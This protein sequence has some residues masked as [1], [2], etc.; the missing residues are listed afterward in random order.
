MQRSTPRRLLAIALV[1]VAIV[2]V[3]CISIFGFY[4]HKY[5]VIVDRR[6]E[7]PLFVNTAQIYAAARQ[8]RT[9]QKLTAATVAAQ[10]RAAGYTDDSAP[11]KSQMGTFAVTDESITIRPGTQSFHAPE[12]ATI[13]FDSSGASGVSRVQQI[14]ATNGEQLAS[15]ALEPLLITGLSD[16]NRAKRRLITYGELPKYL[17]PAVTSIEDRRFFSHGGVDYIRLLGAAR[18]DLLHHGYHGSTEGGSTLTMQLA[19]GFFLTPAKHIK[20]KLLEILIT[21]HLEHRFSKEQIFQLYANEIPLGQAGSFAI[22]GFGEAAQ[23]YFG[24]DVSRLDLPECA[25]LAG[26]IQS[27]SRLTP[28]RHPVRAVERRNLVL[29]AMVETGDI[30]KE[31]AEEAK[32]EPLRLAPLSDQQNKAPYFVDLVRDQI[33][34]KLGDATWNQ[35]GLRIYTSLDPQLQAAA[36]A[37]V[38]EGMKHVDEL[39]D[40]RHAKAA[41]AGEPVVYPQVALVALDPHTGQV[42][43][44]VGGRNYGQ[45]QLNHAASHRPTGSIFK[46]FVYASAFNSSLAG[47]QLTTPD[48]KTGVFN[49]AMMLPDQQQTFEFG[50]GQTYTPRNFEGEYQDEVTAQFALKRSLNNATIL[51]AQMVGFGNVAALARDAGI[52]SARATPSVAIGTYAAS[53]LEMAGAYTIF[54]NG[55]TAIKPQLLASIR[56]SSGDP[57]QDFSAQTHP[58]LDPRVAYLTTNMM[59]AVLQ[60]NGTGAGVRSMGFNAPAAGKTGTENDAW[61]VGYTS[62]LLCIVWVGNDDYSDLKL[63][64]ADAAGPIWGNFMKHAVALPQYSDTHE[65]AVPAGVTL[66]NLDKATNLLADATCPDD[67][68]AAF[69]DGTQPLNTCDGPGNDQRNI[70]QKLFGIGHDQPN[71]TQQQ[72]QQQVPAGAQPALPGGQPQQPAPTTLNGAQPPATVPQQQQQPAQDKKPGFFGRLFGH[73]P[74]QEQAPQQ[75]QPQ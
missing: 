61:F 74:K 60:G 22:N 47:T 70:F 55:G 67:Y 52:V 72:P 40:K 44:L 11:K 20:R 12:D 13:T 14:T 32:A 58:V 33:A 43:A 48:G 9:G 53:P 57:I 21:W 54:A 19:R 10:L 15:Y 39:V 7:K 63:Q 68:T 30:S 17:M 29:D 27:P 8:V 31:Q 65:F 66:V 71:P 49:Q 50:N 46:P 37:A 24:K 62:N 64:G 2:F 51:L 41:A 34:A 56:T 35:Q 25:L 75:Q 26:M 38:D 16:E 59:Q 4:Y 6:L 45:S 3:I 69:L 73:K 28:L 5:G 36:S 18:A 42:L 1:A 23:V